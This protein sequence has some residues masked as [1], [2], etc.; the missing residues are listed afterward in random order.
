VL[1]D[2]SGRRYP[3]DEPRWRGEDGSPL[4][5]E[6]LPGIGRDEI[7]VTTHSHWR[8]ARA[9]PLPLPPLSLGEGR[10]PLLPFD[11]SADHEVWVKP[12]W[13]NPTASFKDRGTSVMLALLAHQGIDAILED[14]SGNGG[15]SVAAYAAAAG[16]TATILAPESTSPAKIRQSRAHGARVELVPGD[17]QATADAALARSATTF[18]ASHNWHPFFLQGTK[19]IAYEIWED[20]GFTAPDAVVLPCGAGSLLL[21]CAIGFA[22][23]LR[24]GQIARVPRLL[25]SQPAHCAPLVAAVHGHV[26]PDRKPTIA[27]GTAIANP[28]RA[29]E[30]LAAVR[31]SNG[32]MVAVPEEQIGPATL[33]LARRGLYAEPTSAQ[34]LPALRAFAPKGRTVMILTGSGLKAPDAVTTLLG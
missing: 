21:G 23:L 18:Y 16:I 9:L 34:V 8:Y 30:V 32:D 24:A 29:P 5:V 13:F 20:L 4:M 19:L 1:T 2:R 11:T 25:V 7:D 12:E 22:E 27:E 17:R 6:P 26:V 3:L 15:S 31:G 14:S 28:V 33:E 10:T